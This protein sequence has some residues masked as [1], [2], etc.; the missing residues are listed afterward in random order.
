MS[1]QK[2]LID[3]S[4]YHRLKG[5]EKEFLENR[6]QK[7]H[8]PIVNDQSGH[9]SSNGND[10]QSDTKVNEQYGSGTLETQDLQKVVIE[11]AN[12]PTD[13]TLLP[14]KTST[15]LSTDDEKKQT[16]K[17]GPQVM[18]LRDDWWCLV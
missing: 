1:V 11:R 4:E 16:L 6:R 17:K 5:M 14:S 13:Q 10:S 8:A 18:E 2:I 9:G 15:V 3:F 7:I 12:G